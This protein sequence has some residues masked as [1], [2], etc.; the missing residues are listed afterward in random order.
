M[1]R[2]LKNRN[3]NMKDFHDHVVYYFQPGN[4][5]PES[6]DPG[7]I[8]KALKKNGLIDYLDCADQF[9]ALL[10]KIKI[11]NEILSLVDELWQSIA[12][13]SLLPPLHALLETVI[14]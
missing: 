7:E 8:V 4:C 10:P 2:K 3:V 11:T 13:Y 9:R 12:E 5:I 1:S 6:S 14:A